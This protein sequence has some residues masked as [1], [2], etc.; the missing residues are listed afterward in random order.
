MPSPSVSS[1]GERHVW[2]SC[3]SRCCALCLHV[4]TV[5]PGCDAR[6]GIDTS[7]RIE[8]PPLFTLASG[9]TLIGLRQ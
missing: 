4:D 7:W 6:L 8:H 2:C 9:Q 1:E 3:G 5:V